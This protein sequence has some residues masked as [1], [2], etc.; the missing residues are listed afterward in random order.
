MCGGR[1]RVT[2]G[3]LKLPLPVPVAESIATGDLVVRAAPGIELMPDAARSTGLTATPVAATPGTADGDDRSEFHFRCFLPDTVFAADRVSR[4]RDVAVNVAT[5]VD[6]RPEQARV[7][8]R[9]EYA[10]RFEPIAELVFDLP[11]ELR[12]DDGTTEVALVATASDGDDNG[13]ERTSGNAVEVCCRLEGRRVIGRCARAHHMRV[14]LPQPRLGRFAVE[15]RYSVSRP[16]GPSSGP[17]SSA[18]W[19]IPLAQPVDGRL[20][21]W[22]AS[23]RTSRGLSVALDPAVEAATWKA[24]R[25]RA[26]VSRRGTGQ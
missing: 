10:V 19:P 12:L 15:L 17:S 6:L 3:R 24:G 18:I 2:R 13:G 4:A 25:I 21:E 11:S 5:H 7:R 23:V 14:A 16:P 8:Q 26:S 22:R 9:V 20:G 1:C